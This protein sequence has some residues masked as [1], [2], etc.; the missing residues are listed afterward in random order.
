MHVTETERQRWGER[1]RGNRVREEEK[2]RVE[3]M[4]GMKRGMER[5]R[6][7]GNGRGEWGDA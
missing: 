3:E 4:A 1:D 2:P 5:M 6:R 7:G